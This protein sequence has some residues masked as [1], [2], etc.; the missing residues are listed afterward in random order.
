MAKKRH[1]EKW[2][3][4][5]AEPEIEQPQLTFKPNS[6]RQVEFL[7]SSE[8]EVL[9]GGASFVGKTLLLVI[10]PLR[11]VGY[12]TFSAVIFRR[13]YPELLRSVMPYCQM[14][15]QAAG[16]VYNEQKKRWT[17]PSSA[18]ID[19]GHMEHENDWTAFQGSSYTA[20]YYDE[21]TCFNWNQYK[22]LAAW[23]RSAAGGIEAFRRSTSNPGGASHSAVKQ[24][25][26][27]PCPPINDGPLRYSEL[28]KTWWQPVKP[29]PPFMWKDEQGRVLSRQFIPGRVFDNEDGI[30]NNPT[31]ITQLFTL[32]PMKRKAFLEGDWNVFE[33][34][35][36]SQWT[37]DVHI[38]DKI[39]QDII[40]KFPL[41]S[42][43]GSIDYGAETILEVLHR[44]YEGDIYRFLEVSSRVGT[45]IER[46]DAMI[47]VLEAYELGNFLIRYDTN[48]DYDLRNYTG[49]DKSPIELFHQQFRKRMGEKAPTFAVVSK[50]SEDNRKYRIACNEAFKQFLYFKQRPQDDPEYKTNRFLVRPKF[51]STRDGTVFNSTVTELIVD[52]DSPGGLDF[53]QGP[54]VQDHAYDS[55]KM[56]LMDLRTPTQPNAVPQQTLEQ[57]LFGDVERKLLGGGEKTWRKI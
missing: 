26:V 8:Y 55:T 37:E 15:Y 12:S 47:D 39:P 22:M 48:M 33:G 17:F 9:F 38:V 42:L 14:Y 52:P 20:H 27:V 23:N 19:L 49:Y 46:A 53:I 3:D 57:F 25:F 50:K 56:A 1:H 11:F 4:P 32:D 5:D 34:Q 45:P 43:R 41:N 51:Y 2:V 28:T 40:K 18:Y 35:F 29:S 24:Y 10:D 44:D 54:E 31:Y 6:Q 21:L 7:A 13:T 30:R 36:F 16:G